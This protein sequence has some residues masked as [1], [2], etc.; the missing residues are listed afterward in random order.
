MQPPLMGG[1]RMIES[2]SAPRFESEVDLLAFETA[3]ARSAQVPW[4]QEA[5]ATHGSTL[6][7]RAAR[8]HAELRSMTRRTRRAWQR[9]LARSS[10]LTRLLQQW[11]ERQAGRALQ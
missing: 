2:R 4:L 5:L 8:C 1:Q 10:G 11:S 6:L 7:P 3:L 9:Q